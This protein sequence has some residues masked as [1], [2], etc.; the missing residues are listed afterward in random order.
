MYES[1]FLP[2]FALTLGLSVACG[3]GGSASGSGA[4]SSSGGSGGHS[5]AT[6]GGGATG[7]GATGGGATGGGATGGGAT[8]GGATG[9]SPT[10][11]CGVT[12]T[13]CS[14]P[15]VTVTEIDVGSPVAVNED[16]A[17]LRILSIAPIPSGGS[18]LAWMDTSSV[19]HVTT[20]DACDKLDAS[21]PTF[22]IPGFDYGDIFADNAGGV[23]LVTRA[24]KGADAKYCGTIQNLCGNVSSLPTQYSCW[25]M[26]MVR[27][28][29]SSETWATQ[30][31]KSRKSYGIRG[32]AAT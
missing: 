28:D 11:A 6:T 12:P 8:G 26:Y 21:H 20:L 18:R 9:G 32:P 29:G 25:D 5:D 14:A 10:A 7:G 27:F 2:I 16:D 19:I 13:G 23:M 4:A 17:A 30:L 15:T 31:S 22:T 3:S 1:K 24:A